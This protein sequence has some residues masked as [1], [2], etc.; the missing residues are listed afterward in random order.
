M[1]R[2]LNLLSVAHYA[3]ADAPASACGV[4]SLA[5]G[6][7]RV[8]RKDAKTQRKSKEV[9]AKLAEDAKE[10]EEIAN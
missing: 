7:E 3:L 5:H 2:D 1:G 6:T 10:N 9:H 4:K 8:S